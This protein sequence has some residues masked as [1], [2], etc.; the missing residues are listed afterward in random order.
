VALSQADIRE[1]QLAKGAMAAGLKML[2]REGVKTLWLAGAFGNYIKPW[3]AREIGL[4]PEDVTVEPVGNS[5]LRGARMLLLAPSKRESR[6]ARLCAMTAHV[7][8]AADAEF[9][10]IYAESMALRPYALR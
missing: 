3:R 6:L 9:Q 8:L 4:L 10:D 5:A 7:E 1:L 2:G